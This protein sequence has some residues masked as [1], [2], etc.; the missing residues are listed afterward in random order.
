MRQTT[1]QTEEDTFQKISQRKRHSNAYPTT[2]SLRKSRKRDLLRVRQSARRTKA[3]IQLINLTK[4][5]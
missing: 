1:N 4:G 2:A 5:E 3:Y